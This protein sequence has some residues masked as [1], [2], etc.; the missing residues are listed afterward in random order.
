MR[1]FPPIFYLMLSF[2]HL[3]AMTDT[4]E[5]AVPASDEQRLVRIYELVQA[6]DK[7]AEKTASDLVAADE[8]PADTK[9]AVERVFTRAI[10]AVD[11]SQEITEFRLL[12]HALQN[13]R[14]R[15]DIQELV[16]KFGQNL[17]VA[18]DQY[19]SVEKGV[20]A[21]HRFYLQLVS[22]IAALLCTN[23]PHTTMNAAEHEP[24]QDI[25]G[26]IEDV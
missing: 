2:A 20:L 16:V 3:N 6:M 14:L 19:A 21:L 12:V 5:A 8:L 18:Y 22:M 15:Q 9:R 23:F 26:K 1:K 25:Y 4:K 7:I 10:K 13:T 17:P 24:S 11:A